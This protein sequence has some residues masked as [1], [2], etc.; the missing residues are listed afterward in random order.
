MT[1]TRKGMATDEIYDVLMEQLVTAIRK[2]DPEYKEKVKLVVEAID[3]DGLRKRKQFTLDDV[4]RRLDF[5]GN[6]YVR[7][8]SR[9]DFLEAVKG[10][11]LPG[12]TADYR[13]SKYSNTL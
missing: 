2:Y 5:D 11:Q 9:R 4:N 8:L 7:M 1:P 3:R 10:R 13:R 12:I 6:R